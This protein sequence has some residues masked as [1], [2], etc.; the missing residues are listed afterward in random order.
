MYATLAAYTGYNPVYDR[1]GM[2]DQVL[3]QL[4]VIAFAK[5]RIHAHLGHVWV[6]VRPR[7]TDAVEPQVARRCHGV[8]DDLHAIWHHGFA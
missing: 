3:E 1:C 2:V 5:G 6:D 7:F 4:R 8:K